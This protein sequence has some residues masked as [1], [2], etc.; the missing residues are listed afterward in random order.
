M[1]KI[2]FCCFL[3]QE[4]RNQIL[5][6]AAQLILNAG[7]T[8]VFMESIGRE[9][10]VSKGLVYAYF[11]TRSALLVALLTRL[12][13]EPGIVAAQGNDDAQIR[14]TTTTWFGGEIAHIYNTDIETVI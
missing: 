2:I 13:N 6:S 7:I 14:D 5:D 10:G 12:S 1:I 4:R 11:A 3:S 9:A 8:A